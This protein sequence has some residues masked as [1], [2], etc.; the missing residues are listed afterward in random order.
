M[1]NVPPQETEDL[2]PPQDEPMSDEEIA[3]MFRYWEADKA[4]VNPHD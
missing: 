3:E 1:H 4:R 2:A